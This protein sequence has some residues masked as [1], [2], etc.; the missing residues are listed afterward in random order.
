MWKNWQLAYTLEGH[1][2][3][4][5]AV[6]A[7]DSNGSSDDEDLVLTGMHPQSPPIVH[8]TDSAL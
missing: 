8:P 3:S 5:W 1:E 2:Q 7:L 4:V 6:L